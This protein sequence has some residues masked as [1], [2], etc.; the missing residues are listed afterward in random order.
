[1]EPQVARPT[2]RPVR[3]IFQE[4]ASS[5]ER[6][7]KLSLSLSWPVLGIMGLVLACAVSWSFFMGFMVGRGQNPEAKFREIAGIE[8]KTEIGA[9]VEEQTPASLPEEPGAKNASAPENPPDAPPA[10]AQSAENN[11]AFRVP[12]GAGLA[13]WGNPLEEKTSKTARPAKK[14]V[15]APAQ[16]NGQQFDYTFQVAAF[17]TLQDA[18]K[19]KKNLAAAGIRC[20]IKK[21]GKVQL[22]IA[23]LRGDA[24]AEK[25]ARQKIKSLKLGEPLLLAKK[26]VA[27]GAKKGK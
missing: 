26:A 20:K 19:S 16:K 21:S 13:A 11:V 2:A 7:A 22:L 10:P 15:N 14:A 17:K 9:P 12:E 8:Q 1:M 25:N 18:E 6:K 5:P 3:K 27:G 24:A 23:S 4:R